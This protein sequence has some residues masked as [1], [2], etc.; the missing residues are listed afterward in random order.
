MKRRT[1]K[2]DDRRCKLT[3]DDDR[4]MRRLYDR[5]TRIAD[6]ARIFKVTR[7]SIYNHLFQTSG[8]KGCRTGG[9]ENM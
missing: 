9:S 3:D 8:D 6:L 7:A 5:G 4:R 2:S 1:P